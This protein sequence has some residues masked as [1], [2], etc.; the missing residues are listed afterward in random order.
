MTNL[1]A[2]CIIRANRNFGQDYIDYAMPQRT[3]FYEACEYDRQKAL[4][5]KTVEKER[6]KE[7]NGSSLSS[8]EYMGRFRKDSR[9]NPHVTLI[10]YYGQKPWDG[11]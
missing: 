2:S 9:L 11:G 3:L 1:Y 8:G 4:I 10:L 6:K 7:L 5:K